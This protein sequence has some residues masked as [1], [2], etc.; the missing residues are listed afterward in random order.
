[1]IALIL[2]IASLA[3]AAPQAAGTV[4]DCGILAVGI[5]DKWSYTVPADAA[6][7]CCA[8][9]LATS[10]IVTCGGDDGTSIVSLVLPASNLKGAVP[11]SLPLL[12]SL[13]YLDISQNPDVTTG[14]QTLAGIASLKNLN[15][16]GTGFTGAV[17]PFPP[18]LSCNMGNL[19]CGDP[20]CAQT[21]SVL[22]LC[23]SPK[24]GNNNASDFVA[25]TSSN[26]L[27]ILIGVFGGALLLLMLMC[28]FCNQRGAVALRLAS[29]MQG[30]ASDSKP[31]AVANDFVGSEPEPSSNEMAMITLSRNGIPKRTFSLPE[32][33]KLQSK[34]EAAMDVSAR[35]PFIV[36][37]N[38]K[39]SFPVRRF[40]AKEMSDELSLTDGDSV[41]LTKVFRDGWAEGVSMRAGGPALFPLAC[42]G[43]GVPIVLA[44][45]LR[46]ARL[47]ARGGPS[48]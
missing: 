12:K 39:E 27:Y 42:L 34:D 46:V 5:L 13:T 21:G 44:E 40:Y 48:A 24:A 2:G 19:L 47:M 41:V 16:A 43:G 4:T 6:T 9:S 20:M 38:G 3:A 29:Q 36:A 35:D 17:I 14:L 30:A 26:V 11:V 37:N 28:Y 22:K 32:T 10:G 18:S 15:I 45:R 1:M 25:P 8:G 7:N 23:P 31:Y 33:R